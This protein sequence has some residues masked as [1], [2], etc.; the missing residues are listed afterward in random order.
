MPAKKQPYKYILK[1]GY[2]EFLVPSTQGID[3]IMRILGNAVCVHHRSY[4]NTIEIQKNQPQVGI[5]MIRPG[6]VIS[7]ERDRED[8]EDDPISQYRPARKAKQLTAEAILL[9]E[10]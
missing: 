3:T 9:L 8:E 7:Y 10:D 2:Q 6:A 5:E 1:I 4:S